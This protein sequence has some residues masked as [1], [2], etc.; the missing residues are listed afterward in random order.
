MRRPTVNVTQSCPGVPYAAVLVGIMQTAS[1]QRLT[2]TGWEMG[3]FTEKSGEQQ[4][5]GIVERT[6]NNLVID[7]QS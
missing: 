5:H 7:E 4:V 6:P 2:A 3:T 1:A